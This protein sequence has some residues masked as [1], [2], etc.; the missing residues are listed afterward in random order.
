MRPI[1]LALRL[2]CSATPT[3]RPA[4]RRSNIA[5]LESKALGTSTDNAHWLPVRSVPCYLKNAGFLAVR[6]AA[7]PGMPEG[8]L[9]AYRLQLLE[10][11]RHRHVCRRLGRRMRPVI[12]D[13]PACPGRRK[14]WPRCWCS[15][16]RDRCAAALATCRH[17]WPRAARRPHSTRA[18][19]VQSVH[20]GQRLLVQ[21]ACRAKRFRITETHQ[22][23]GKTR[24]PRGTPSTFDPVELHG[25]RP[26][27]ILILILI[28]Q[29]RP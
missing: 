6:L 22:P 20:P 9:L 7:V 23:K 21:R 3:V 5:A 12:A 25:N 2:L 8:L 13:R 10:R 28:S 17:G 15:A 24:L 4:M 14:R 19:H 11:N 16:P 27:L 1:V 18:L 26:I 29:V